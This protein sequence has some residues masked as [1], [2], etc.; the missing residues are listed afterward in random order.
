MNMNYVALCLALALSVAPRVAHADITLNDYDKYMSEPDT[1][2]LM[3][4]Y[5]GGLVE[6]LLAGN[7]WDI[8][9]GKEPVYCLPGNLSLQTA[10]AISILD[11]YVAWQHPPKTNELGLVMMNALQSVF[12]CT[13]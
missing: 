4:E 7:A 6:G 3:Q 5:V 12:P 2:L 13:Q 8:F 1:Q 9:K 11:N 10:Q